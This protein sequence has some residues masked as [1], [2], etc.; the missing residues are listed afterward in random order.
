MT[1][2]KKH[3]HGEVLRNLIFK[4]KL[5]HREVAKGIGKHP[6][7]LSRLLKD[8]EISLGI[9]RESSHFFKVPIEIFDDP[10]RFVDLMDKD[11]DTDQAE[12][13]E[14]GI[15]YTKTTQMDRI[16]AA[17]ERMADMSEKMASIVEVQ[18]KTIESQARML[19]KLLINN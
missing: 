2:E 17:L 4:S 3:H 13:N 9:R 14:P 19:E 12:V 18:A 6:N 7:Y 11:S 1:T 16:T 15:K 8:E 10:D 5:E